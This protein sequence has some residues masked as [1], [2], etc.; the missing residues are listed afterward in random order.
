MAKGANSLKMEFFD[1]M[2]RRKPGFVELSY[3]FA[4]IKC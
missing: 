3:V 1:V 2:A 4:L